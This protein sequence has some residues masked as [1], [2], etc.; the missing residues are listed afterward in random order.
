MNRQV[1]RRIAILNELLDLARIEPRR[2]AAFELESTHLAAL[3]AEG[4]ANVKTPNGRSAPAWLRGPHEPAPDSTGALVRIDRNEVHQALGNV[5]SNA[6]K[7]SPAGGALRLQLLAGECDADG[8][9]TL[10]GLWLQDSG[11]GLTPAPPT[12]STP[13]MAALH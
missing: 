5:L 11:I 8:Q 9:P 2:G 6:C 10:W 1:E 7:Y 13:T 12:P 3:L 4:V